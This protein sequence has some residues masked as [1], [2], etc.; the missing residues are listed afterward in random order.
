MFSVH[1]LQAQCSQQLALAQRTYD[2][3]KLDEVNAILGNCFEVGF[4]KNE[5]QRAYRL[6]ALTYLYMDRK[7]EAADAMMRLLQEEPEY[8]L[9]IEDPAEFV[10]LYKQFRTYPV[11][12][13]G[14]VFGVN[15]TYVHVDNVFGVQNTEQAQGGYGTQLGYQ[16]G[17]A[18]QLPLLR[19]LEFSGEFW[20]N[21]QRFTYANDLYAYTRTSFVERQTWFSLPLSLRLLAGRGKI[22]PFLQGGVAAHF[23]QEAQLEIGRSFLP[24]IGEILER[25]PQD[26]LISVRESNLRQTFAWTPLLAVGVNYKVP[27][28]VISVQARYGLG[29][30]NIVQAENR[31][32]NAELI[33]RYG[34]L[35][36]D[37]RTNHL[38]IA[39]HVFYNLYKPKL[40]KTRKPPSAT[41][42]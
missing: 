13:V 40:R 30:Q 9:K 4:T 21:Q 37:F 27:R 39:V 5:R 23:L 10:A 31:Y 1:T 12:S 8:A 24:N 26:Q 38:Q 2:A 3:G 33:Y 36:D 34:H 7:E 11:A 28:A 6:L 16:V 41:K 14:I 19:W 15:T 35:D 17:L 42:P 20:L 32:T 29:M 22:R 18:A 25:E